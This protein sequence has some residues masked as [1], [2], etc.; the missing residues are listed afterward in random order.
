MWQHEH[1]EL[2]EGDYKSEKLYMGEVA[3]LRSYVAQRPPFDVK[4]PYMAPIKVNKNIYNEGSDRHC[5]HI[6]VTILLEGSMILPMLPRTHILKELSVYTTD[7]EQRAAGADGE[8]HG[9]GQGA[10][11][12]LGGGQ[13]PPHR[14]HPRGHGHLLAQTK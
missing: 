1:K 6:E 11:P 10:V 5:M 7:P 13:L 4:N 8:H 12:E 9:G 3:R 14:P 2:S